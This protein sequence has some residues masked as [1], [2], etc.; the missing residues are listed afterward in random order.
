MTMMNYKGYLAI[1]ELDE[2][3]DIFYGKLVGINQ[4][5]TFEADNAHDL[6]HA[7]YD[8][9]DDYLAFCAENNLQPD[10]PFKGSFNV[11]IGDDLHRRAVMASQDS[12]LNAFITEAIRE[13]LLRLNA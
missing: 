2:D 12:S 10:K 5:V 6:R 13:K 4:L 1:Y 9:V 7:F 11:R 3:D 8:A